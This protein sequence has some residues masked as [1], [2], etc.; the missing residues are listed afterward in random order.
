MFSTREEAAP[1]ACEDGS[2]LQSTVIRPGVYQGQ[3]GSRVRGSNIETELILDSHGC[4]RYFLI[5]S[6]TA[7]YTAKGR[8][9]ASDEE[10]LLSRVIRAGLNEGGFSF[11][12]TLNA[13]D[14]SRLRNVYESS[15]ERQEAFFDSLGIPMLLWVTYHRIPPQPLLSEGRYEFTELFRDWFDTNAVNFG[16]TRIR[17]NRGGSF[18]EDRFQNGKPMF[19]IEDFSWK[20]SGSFFISTDSHIRFPTDSTGFSEWFHSPPDYE[21]ITRLQNIGASSFQFW[22]G[23]DYTVQKFPIWAT[24]KAKP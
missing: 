23:A 10:M 18:F 6:N 14:S 22:L 11:W 7:F 4:F 19:E 2:F 8:W 5:D 1:T 15:F 20:Q 17:L 13:P 9:Q 3:Y 21:F 24:F 12:D 16:L